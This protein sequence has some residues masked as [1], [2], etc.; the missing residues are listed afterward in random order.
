M[1]LEVGLL[2]HFGVARVFTS[3]ARLVERGSLDAV[4]RS[5]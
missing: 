4:G 2:L 3:L 1:N 5:G